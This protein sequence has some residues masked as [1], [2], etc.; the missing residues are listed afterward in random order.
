MDR[1]PAHVG[2]ENQGLRR[3]PE[4]VIATILNFAS[5]SPDRDPD[6]MVWK[7]AKPTRWS[8][9]RS[10]DREDFKLKVR[11]SMRQSQ[12]NT[13]KIRAFDQE[14]SLQYFA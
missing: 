8:A 6:E 12:N 3:Q 1:G 9:W 13:A 11:S 2:Q 7:H 5:Y 14:P 10:P 4:G